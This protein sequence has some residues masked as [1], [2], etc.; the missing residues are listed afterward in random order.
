MLICLYSQVNIHY[1]VYMFTIGTYCQ[2][3]KETFK[4][5]SLKVLMLNKL[6]LP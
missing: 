5:F 1:H 4:L 3:K 2:Y 6:K